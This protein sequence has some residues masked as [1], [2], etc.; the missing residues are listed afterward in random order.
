MLKLNCSIYFNL[1]NIKVKNQ[2]ACHLNSHKTLIISLSGAETAC[3]TTQL[4][5]QIIIFLFEHL[6]SL[7]YKL[8]TKIFQFK[9][10]C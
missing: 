5:T 2:P 8:R 3:N 4:T 7:S 10:V 1:I 6:S 9:T